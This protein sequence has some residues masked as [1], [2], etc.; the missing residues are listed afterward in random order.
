MWIYIVTWTISMLIETPNI[1]T[2]I[3]KNKFGQEIKYEMKKMEWVNSDSL[4]QE[5]TNR[6]SAFAFYE[7]LLK[8]KSINSF[9]KIIN[10]NIDSVYVEIR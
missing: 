2:T 3:I 6:D 4:R 10:K 9:E 7:E 5:F 8:A 1:E